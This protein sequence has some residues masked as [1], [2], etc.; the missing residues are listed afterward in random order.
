M[1]GIALQKD[2][3]AQIG[4]LLNFLMNRRIMLQMMSYI[5]TI[6]KLN[7]ILCLQKIKEPNSQKNLFEALHARVDADL[8]GW[9]NIDIFAP[10]YLG[11]S[12]TFANEFCS[13]VVRT[14]SAVGYLDSSNTFALLA[15]LPTRYLGL[16]N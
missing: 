15:Q 16:S 2:L 13:L 14:A 1:L 6:S 3:G 9:N 11:L 4:P 7:S 8:A 12:N 5:C 10:Q